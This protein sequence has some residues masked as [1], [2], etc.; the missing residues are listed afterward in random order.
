MDAWYKEHVHATMAQIHRYGPPPSGKVIGHFTA[1]VQDRSNVVG[2]VAL[3]HSTV[4]NDGII[5]YHV[6]FVCNYGFTNFGGQAVYIPVAKGNSPGNGCVTKTDQTYTGLCNK[7]EVVTPEPYRRTMP[8]MRKM[9]PIVTKRY[10]YIDAM[11]REYGTVEE[12][13]AKGIYPIEKKALPTIQ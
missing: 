4:D 3:K 11:G 8:N 13:K 1:I 5:Y 10:M 2:C 7:H 12:A 9:E 6:Y